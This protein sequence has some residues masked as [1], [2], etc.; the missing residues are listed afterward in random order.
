MR[1]DCYNKGSM[2][3]FP[4]ELTELDGENYFSNKEYLYPR[5]VLEIQQVVE[6]YCDRMEYDGSVMYDEYPDK[7]LVERMA[8]RICEDRK[9]RRR[10]G[11]DDSWMKAL[12]QVLLC[13]EMSFRRE[14]RHHHKRNMRR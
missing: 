8:G 5:D 7:A 1:E 9:C 6:E 2:L 13:G 14:R 4:L 3:T 11:I 12:V 10:Q